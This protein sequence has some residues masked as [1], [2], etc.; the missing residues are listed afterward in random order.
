[1]TAFMVYSLTVAVLLNWCCIQVQHYK[2]VKPFL[3]S[4]TTYGKLLKSALFFAWNLHETADECRDHGCCRPDW[5]CIGLSRCLGRDAGH[6]S[7]HQPA[8]A[9]NHSSV[10]VSGRRGH[11]AQ[12]LRVLNV[13]QNRSEEHT[14]ELQSLRH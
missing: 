7:T 10:A 8:L 5:L 12:G 13:K 11:G 2:R 3:R 6:R 14:S 1:M 4:V 9:R